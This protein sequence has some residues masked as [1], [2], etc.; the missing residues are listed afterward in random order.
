MN[1][2]VG[3][4][5]RRDPKRHVR[6]APIYHPYIGPAGRSVRRCEFRKDVRAGV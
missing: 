1:T 4:G 5:G 3:S 6:S 2:I